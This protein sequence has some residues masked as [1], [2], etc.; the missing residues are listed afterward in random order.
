MK[1]KRKKY[2]QKKLKKKREKKIARTIIWG[3]KLPLPH[4]YTLLKEKKI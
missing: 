4:N 2:L 3:E 1:K